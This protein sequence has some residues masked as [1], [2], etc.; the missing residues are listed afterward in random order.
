MTDWLRAGEPHGRTAARIEAQQLGAR[1]ICGAPMTPEVIRRARRVL[2]ASVNEYD[3]VDLTTMVGLAKYI[4]A[5]EGH[6]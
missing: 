4:A 2:R 5:N 1:V 6:S 3:R